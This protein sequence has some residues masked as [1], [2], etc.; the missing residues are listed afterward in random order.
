MAN[1][2]NGMAVDEVRDK[3]KNLVSAEDWTIQ[4]KTGY[5]YLKGAMLRGRLTELLGLNI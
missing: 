3:L 4:D 2:I 1:T 5:P